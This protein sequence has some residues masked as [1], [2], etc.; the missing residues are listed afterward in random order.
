MKREFY[1]IVIIIAK[2]ILRRW[3]GPIGTHV[4]E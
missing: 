3:Y 1:K 4:I 2:E